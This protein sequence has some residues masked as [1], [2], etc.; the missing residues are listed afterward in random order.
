MLARV[1]LN[2]KVGLHLWQRCVFFYC[3]ES[4]FF[5]THLHKAG[6][7]LHFE[8]Q[9]EHHYQQTTFGNEDD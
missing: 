9:K 4:K 1:L 8:Y 6:V 3:Y 2:L 7:R 5:Y